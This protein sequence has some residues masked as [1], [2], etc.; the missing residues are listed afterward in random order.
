MTLP[1]TH[2]PVGITEAQDDRIVG[3]A[4]LGNW[5][6][7]LAATA[8][9]GPKGIPAQP[10]FKEVKSHNAPA[11]SLG[12]DYDRAVET[13]EIVHQVLDE[14][15]KVAVHLY[16]CERVSRHNLAKCGSAFHK[17][18]KERMTVRGFKRYLDDI[19][20]RVGVCN[21]LKDA[22]IK[23]VPHKEKAR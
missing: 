1:N 3:G 15:M 14:K 8:Q 4:L 5:G 18:T 16:Y 23:P 17:L 13:Q 10:M 2:R 20:V 9:P 21:R 12:Y 7:W 19:C 11:G 22:G 6:N